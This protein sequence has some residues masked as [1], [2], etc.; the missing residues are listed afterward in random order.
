M[1]K[2]EADTIPELRD[3]DR[4]GVRAWHGTVIVPPNAELKFD[5]PLADEDAEY[6]KLYAQREREQMEAGFARPMGV[7]SSD[8]SFTGTLRLTPPRQYARPFPARAF[9]A[10]C[11][12]GCFAWIGIVAAIRWA[13][14]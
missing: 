2:R 8:A 3:K 12:A 9:L 4:N 1:T 7:R 10:F 11:V 6:W 14:Q 13:M 5:V